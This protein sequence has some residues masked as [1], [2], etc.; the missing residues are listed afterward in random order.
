M[1]LIPKTAEN[2]AIVARGIAGM[3]TGEHLPKFS[4][5]LYT[6]SGMLASILGG[7]D[8]PMLI[9][10]LADSN[11]EEHGRKMLKWALD[12]PGV[13]DR[14]KVMNMRGLSRLQEAESTMG[15]AKAWGQ[16][17]TLPS[18]T[19]EM[20]QGAFDWLRGVQRLGGS[21]AEESYF[22]FELFSM[23]CLPPFS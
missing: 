23:V 11:G 5:F 8:D 20:V 13:M 4:M 1:I 16:A 22:I 10:H 18:I 9:I 21:V 12:I 15:K 6:I 17:I 7:I 19:E 14:T 3:E 2:E